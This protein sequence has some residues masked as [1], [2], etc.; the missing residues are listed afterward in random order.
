MSPE[1][2]FNEQEQRLFTKEGWLN[3]ARRLVNWRWNG[4]DSA[5]PERQLAHN[6]IQA[7]AALNSGKA[8]DSATCMAPNCIIHFNPK[9][10]TSGPA[11]K[12]SSFVAE[13]VEPPKFSTSR[14][15]AIIPEPPL[16]LSDVGLHPLKTRFEKGLALCGGTVA[17][18]AIVLG[19]A[20]VK[21]GITGY[22]D[23]ATGER[24]KGELAHLLVGAAEIG[25]GT[26]GLLAA[27]TG[28]IKLWK[29]VQSLVGR[30]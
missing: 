16:R 23:P 20:T 13:T 25:A 29:P 15:L 7:S 26:A 1:T 21:K 12:K 2:R 19:A 3:Y 18:G 30:S 4:V 17:V 9:S 22:E 5:F 27:T 11:K 24:K 10:P 8:H 14:E 28:R 6:V